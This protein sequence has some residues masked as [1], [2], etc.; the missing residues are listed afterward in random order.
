MTNDS[1]VI[2]ILE[3][4]RSGL[5]A[6]DWLAKLDRGALTPAEKK[7]FSIW[8]AEDPSRHQEIKA[9]ATMWY[10][11]DVP[12]ALKIAS[13]EPVVAQSLFDRVLAG[14]TSQVKV[15]ASIGIVLF[16]AVSSGY[17]LQTPA[18]E[19]GYFTT[20]IGET[21]QLALSDGS[22]VTL[23][24]NSII[25]QEYTQDQRVIRLVSGEAI[26]EVAHEKDRPFLVYA[27]DGIIK[28]IGTKFAVRV[29]QN[30]VSVT[31]TEGTIALV[32][33]QEITERQ[34]AEADVS[35][36]EKIT[37][38]LMITAGEAGVINRKTGAQKQQVSERDV[39]ER[40]SWQ[41]GQLVFYDRELQAVVE[42]VARYTTMTI[43]VEGDELRRRQITGILTIGDVD[44]MIEGLEAALDVK[45]NRVSADTVQLVSAQALPNALENLPQNE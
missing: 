12:L 40:L 6:S 43:Q 22:V 17:F 4:K 15:L 31:V 7:A 37:E 18:P 24:T 33:R 29:N 34:H 27:S 42:E 5:Q 10:G 45:A 14:F 16:L 23:N 19:K 30:D 41:V 20:E 26:F 44:Q 38:P 9:L 1:E 2:S 13:R 35:G 25:D 39:N 11:I 32:E 21:R 36:Q 8:L 3:G 28:A